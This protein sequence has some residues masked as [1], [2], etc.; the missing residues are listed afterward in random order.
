MR[1]TPG[2]CWR[3]KLRVLC[4]LYELRV[5]KLHPNPGMD[6]HYVM[7]EA[8]TEMLNGE[9]GCEVCAQAASG[10]EAVQLADQRYARE[11]LDLAPFQLSAARR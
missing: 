2:E 11:L 7:R 8:V 6:D 5:I 9:D 10:H 4:F 3:F 1:K